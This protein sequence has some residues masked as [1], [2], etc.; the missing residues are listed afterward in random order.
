MTYQ[1]EGA[2]LILDKYNYFSQQAEQQFM[3]CSQYLSFIGMGGNPGCEAK[4]MAKIR[5]EW[6]E[7]S[8]TALQVGSYLHSHFEGPQAKKEFIANCPEMFLK[9]GGL[10]SEYRQA[11]QM[12]A[13]LESDEFCMYML[14]GE[15]EVIM[16]A[17][18]FGMWWKVRFDKYLPEKRRGAD[19]K[20]T[21]SVTE[22]DWIIRDAKNVKASF[23]ECYEYPLRAAIY[24]E[25]ERIVTGHEEGDWSDFY[26][27]AVSKEDPPDKAVINM[28]DPYRYAQEL[29]KVRGSLTRIKLLKQGV[30]QPIRCERCDYCRSTKKL[31]RVIHYSDL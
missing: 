6:I 22:H 16:T 21:K 8:S 10:K 28:T 25:V 27:V 5:G 13:T 15:S 31:E 14:Q 17:E 2:P 3:S 30:L 18:L 29:E 7:E 19:I 23:V 24:S 12:I 9:G 26:I 20:T 4:T 1:R 11:D